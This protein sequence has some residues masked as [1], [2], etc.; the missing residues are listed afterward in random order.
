MIP[1]DVL[2]KARKQMQPNARKSKHMPVVVVP[3][4]DKRPNVETVN[5]RTC[6]T[7]GKDYLCGDYYD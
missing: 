3:N 2:E 6:V 1:K 7:V 5:G 4:S